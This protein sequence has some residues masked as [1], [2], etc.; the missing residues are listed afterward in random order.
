[1][2]VQTIDVE[3]IYVAPPVITAP[4]DGTITNNNKPTITGTG[5]AGATVTVYDNGTSIGT[6]Q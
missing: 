5:E 3:N 2:A 1:M 4:T 6:A